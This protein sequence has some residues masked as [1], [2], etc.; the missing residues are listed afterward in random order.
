M[1]D[2]E[3]ELNEKYMKE[4]S[5]WL[6]AQNLSSKTINKHINNVDLYIN[7][8]MNYYE[9]TK[10]ED[11]VNMAYDFFND[12]FIRKCLWVTNN[13][14][15]ETATSVKKFYHCMCE[16]GY[17]DA[18]GYKFLCLTIKNNMD[19]FRETLY[20]FDNFDDED[21]DDDEDYKD[22]DN[23]KE[24]DLREKAADFII[25]LNKMFFLN[26][27]E[28]IKKYYK[29]R[30]IHSN[31][32][33]SMISYVEKGNYPVVDYFNEIIND[34]KREVR[35]LQ[36]DIDN[37]KHNDAIIFNELFFYKNHSK[38]PFLTEK[39]IEMKKFKDVEKI[40]MLYAM[41]NSTV[42]LFKKI[43]YDQEN[44]YVTYQDV[45]TNKKYKVI[46]I[47]MSSLGELYKDV[48][49]YCYDRIINYDGILFGTGIP[50]VFTGEN[51]SLKE[52]IKHHNYKTCS[53]FSR[54]LMLY[55]ISKEE[56][57]TLMINYHNY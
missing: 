4:F 29:A 51:K 41:K 45:F 38:I 37:Q 39:Y 53:D 23:N 44:G 25:N 14:L 31:V 49:I 40:K 18:E 36:I 54:C 1:N 46:D 28:H 6:N 27:K 15:K 7:D 34:V 22:D 10:M 16:K 50:C 33:N 57:N 56:K 43:K 48:E 12:W 2:Y 20:E 52:F 32:L 35:N 17:V 11:G 21:Y 24:F 19:V 9:V 55:D 8:Y 30:K 5:D 47:S 26:D 42:G 3:K 13:S